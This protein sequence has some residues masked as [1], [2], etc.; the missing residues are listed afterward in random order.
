VKYV[1]EFADSLI[2]II[3]RK[4]AIFY[5]HGMKMIKVFLWAFKVELVF[6]QNA[7]ATTLKC[8]YNKA[9]QLLHKKPSKPKN[10]VKTVK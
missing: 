9:K 1:L 10:I 7:M 2:A 5:G 8:N 4:R 3:L 6:I